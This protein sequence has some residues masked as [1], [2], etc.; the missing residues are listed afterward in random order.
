MIGLDTSKFELLNNDYFVKEIVTSNQ[1]KSD[2]ITN[3][4]VLGEL[5]LLG[6]DHLVLD[7]SIVTRN[8]DDEA[9]WLMVACR[10]EHIS[11]IY[12]HL[13]NSSSLR[14]EW[15]NI[16]VRPMNT[17][18]IDFKLLLPHALQKSNS[19]TH[20]ELTNCLMRVGRRASSL[21]SFTG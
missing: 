15:L 1:P 14:N 7:F 17:S 16:C 18:S 10:I 5:Q 8:R 11:D 19:T 20:P 21:G 4:Q 2:L 3:A 13:Q 9:P 6:I 12:S